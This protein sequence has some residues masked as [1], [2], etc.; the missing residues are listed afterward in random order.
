MSFEVRHIGKSM[1]LGLPDTVESKTV[2]EKTVKDVR[3]DKSASAG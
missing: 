2:S 3:Q 1:Y